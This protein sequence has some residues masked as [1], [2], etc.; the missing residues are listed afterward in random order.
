MGGYT[1][2]TIRDPFTGKISGYQDLGGD[3][4][5]YTGKDVMAN[6]SF[7]PN[8]PATDFLKT[9]DGRPDISNLAYVEFAKQDSKPLAIVQDTP[10]NP[11][12]TATNNP[13]I[14]KAA[15]AGVGNTNRITGL[16]DKK[17]DVPR[18]R[19]T[20]NWAFGNQDYEGVY[21]PTE[22]G[23]MTL[24][25]GTIAGGE[26]GVSVMGTLYQSDKGR[27]QV[28][29]KLGHLAM[30]GSE[31][32]PLPTINKDAYDIDPWKS[33]NN[34]VPPP[35]ED[36]ETSVTADPLAGAISSGGS[37]TGA[38]SI[39]SSQ[40]I[41][42]YWVEENGRWVNPQTPEWKKKNNN[43]YGSNT[44]GSSNVFDDPLGLSG[45]APVVKRRGLSPVGNF[46]SALKQKRRAP[47]NKQSGFMSIF[48]TVKG[49]TPKK[50]TNPKNTDTPYGLSYASI[51]GTRNTKPSKPIKSPIKKPIQSPVKKPTTKKK[52]IGFDN[53]YEVL[54]SNKR[55]K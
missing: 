36:T 23:T 20:K 4:S 16:D 53:A 26:K 9:T 38:L 17:W 46:G 7:N 44:T 28:I 11:Y 47:H 35:P 37:L 50:A 24:G 43:P 6:S 39:G 22:K 54:F 8:K 49:N 18:S 13:E 55:G 29:D 1:S 19:E 25:A 3:S 32:A 14:T 21:K 42:N 10:N 5:L 40:P 45:G 27:W 41:T 30:S 2:I 52:E 15:M 48:N 12:L 31:G 33:I 51:R 34:Y